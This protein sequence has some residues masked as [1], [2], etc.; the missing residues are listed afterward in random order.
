MIEQTPYGR[1][2]ETSFG[3][4]NHANDY[5]QEFDQSGAGYW[6]CDKKPIVDLWNTTQPAFGS[7][8]TIY[9]EFLFA[10]QVYKH[11]DASAANPV[12]KPFFIFYASHI[13]HTPNQIPKQYLSTWDNDEDECSE[14]PWVIYPGFNTSNSSN[15]HCRSITQSQVN[16]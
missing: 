5:W 16:L 11:I 10:Q 6:H 12:Y 3:Y 4:L 15:Y 13:S 8:N 9:E 7:N 1:G 2:Y 14:T